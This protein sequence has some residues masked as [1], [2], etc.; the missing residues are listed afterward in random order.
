M[1]DLLAE[2][3]HG[4]SQADREAAV[5]AALPLA[6]SIARRYR[7][8]GVDH[9][10][11]LQVA[12][13]GLV[14]AVRGYRPGSPAGF[15][16][17]AVPTIVGEVKR[18]FRDHEWLVRPPRALQELQGEVARERMQLGQQLGRSAK[19]EEV[20]DA[21]GI[22]PVRVR[23]ASLSRR[24]YSAAPSGPEELLQVA[25]HEDQYER[26]L[27]RAHLRGVLAGLSDRDAALFR[28][29]F[30]EERSQAD[31]GAELGVSQ[32]QVSRLLTKLLNRL[33]ILL[34]PEG[35][36]QRRAG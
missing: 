14:K 25:A 29:R 21:L 15:T 18:H 36:T 17:Y 9:D 1:D 22:S 20:A 33:R 4:P 23:D 24:A 35:S 31:I 7:G 26:V 16:A 13:L 11:L 28:M 5:V 2:S 32:V 27:D 19:D 10:D 3:E 30:I 8:R 12:R 6:E 34:E